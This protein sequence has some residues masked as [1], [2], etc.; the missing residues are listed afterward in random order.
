MQIS[1]ILHPY[2]SNTNTINKNTSFKRDVTTQ[3][4]IDSVKN[5]S[6]KDSEKRVMLDAYEK[7]KDYI[8]SLDADISL[9][10]KPKD[11]RKSFFLNEYLFPEELGFNVA[12]KNRSLDLIPMSVNVIDDVKKGIDTDELVDIIKFKIKDV[13]DYIKRSTTYCPSGNDD[14][15]TDNTGTWDLTD[16]Y[17]P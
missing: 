8:D 14:F 11:K 13:F 9:H 17:I 2:Y 12:A 3:K 4:N 15:Y 6:L 7:T 16:A 5:S 10:Y 1:P